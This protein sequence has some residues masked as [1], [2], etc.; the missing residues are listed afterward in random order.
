MANNDTADNYARC[1]Q[2]VQLVCAAA[3]PCIQ[4]VLTNWHNSVKQKLTA[5]KTPQTCPTKGKPKTG[6]GS[7]SSC[8]DWSKELEAVVYPPNLSGSLP[9]ANLNPTLLHTDPMEAAKVFVLRLQPGVVYSDVGDFDAASLIMIMMKFVE[10]HRGDV[11]LHAKIKK[12]RSW[13][14]HRFQDL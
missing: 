13:T 9:W 5:C 14:V 12:V 1:H 3:I 10:F 7:C 11:T 4:S 6:R 2:A 8:V